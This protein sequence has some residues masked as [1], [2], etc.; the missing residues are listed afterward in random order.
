MTY[1][2]N[3]SQR[4]IRH[5]VETYAHYLTADLGNVHPDDV[6]TKAR[7]IAARF[8]APEFK[9]SLSMKQVVGTQMKF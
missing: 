1:E 5:G 3:V 8:P 6:T 7:E 9:C 4:T 2:F